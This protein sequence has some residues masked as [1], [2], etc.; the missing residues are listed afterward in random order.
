MDIFLRGEHLVG[1]CPYCKHERQEPADPAKNPHPFEFI[2][3]CLFC[4]R[5]QYPDENAIE[6]LVAQWQLARD[7]KDAGGKA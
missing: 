2:S 1:R 3:Y 5:R 6:R 4:G 7:T